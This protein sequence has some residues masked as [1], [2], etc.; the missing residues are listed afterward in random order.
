M[1]TSFHS[2][3]TPWLFKVNF[4]GNNIML[5]Q[6]KGQMHLAMCR[7]VQAAR[8]RWGNVE[9]LLSPLWL[10]L[11]HLSVFCS[12][13]PKLT[14]NSRCLWTL[15]KN[16]NTRNQLYSKTATTDQHI[17]LGKLVTFHASMFTSGNGK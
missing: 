11:L 7:Q 12:P 8:T 13:Y 15:D 10:Q 16:L 5:Q 1:L 6:F 9:T 17:T 3:L 14:S 4:V 2:N